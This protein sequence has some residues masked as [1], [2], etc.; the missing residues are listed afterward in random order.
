MPGSP[1]VRCNAR[2]LATQYAN[3]N[4]RFSDG[5]R[6]RL[7]RFTHEENVSEVLLEVA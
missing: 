2:G 7:G 1:K 6:P 3:I 4:V 5:E